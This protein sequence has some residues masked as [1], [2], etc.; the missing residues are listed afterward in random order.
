MRETHP[1]DT[2]ARG[3]LGP[4]PETNLPDIAIVPYLIIPTIRRW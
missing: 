1:F 2:A 4:P 3:L